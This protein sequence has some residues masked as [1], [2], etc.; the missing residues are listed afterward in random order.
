MRKSFYFVAALFAFIAGPLSISTAFAAPSG[1]T[2][3]RGRYQTVEIDTAISPNISHLDLIGSG[4]TLTFTS[5]NV[6]VNRT[7]Y[8]VLIPS[9]Y[10]IGNYSVRAYFQDGTT[11]DYANVKV[12]E[13]QS[14]GYNPAADYK[15]TAGIALTL[16]T[17]LALWS[18]NT[19]LDVNSSSSSQT[20]YEG[21]ESNKIAGKLRKKEEYSKGLISSIGLDQFRSNSTIKIG[22]YSPLGSRLMA[23]GG[24]L[25]YSL[26][27]L[28]LFFPALGVALGVLAFH[29]I[30]GIGHITT[31]SL[32]I[33]TSLI[34]LSCLD[35]GAGFIGFVTFAILTTSSHFISNPYDFRTLLGLAILWIAPAMM[36]SGTRPLRRTVKEVGFWER[37]TDVIVGSLIAGWGVKNLVLALDGFAHLKLPLDSH[38]AICGIAAGLTLFVRYLIEDYVSFKNHAYLNYLSPSTIHEQDS[39]F[40]ILSWFL[41]GILYTF[42]AVSFLGIHWELWAALVLFMIPN[43]L[44]EYKE[45]FRNSSLLFQILPVGIP[46]VVIMLLI[47]RGYSHWIESQ[48]YGPVDKTRIIF[49]LL[50]IPGFLISFL[51]LFGRSAKTG[52][53]RWYM[54]PKMSVA[55]KTAGPLVLGLAIA[56]TLG[57][58]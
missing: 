2:W 36:A 23:D 39:N 47:N 15:R 28:V 46:S 19:G 49:V 1:L 6:K 42:F 45:N 51:R 30:H 33:S 4:K 38:A 17:L 37:S 20:T 34:V 55:Y 24:Y 31:P 44:K 22:R 53:D 25:Q 58:I 57:V 26:G 32:A 35:S 50:A 40:T 18:G 54:R 11:L 13:Y 48:N 43:I 41:K 14:E 29:D 52:D 21:I 16:F 10:P 27:S 8:Q 3:E 12:V 9:D 5:A 7:T 56:M